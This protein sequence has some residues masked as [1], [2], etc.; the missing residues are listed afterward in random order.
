M[1]AVFCL[2]QV[3]SA[4]VQTIAGTNDPS[5]CDLDMSTAESFITYARFCY[6]VGPPI[7]DRGWWNAL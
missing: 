2:V 3:P 5:A 1:V 7:A 6:Y 4:Q